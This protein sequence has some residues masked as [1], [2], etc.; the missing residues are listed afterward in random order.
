MESHLYIIYRW[1]LHM[2]EVK[3][4]QLICGVHGVGKTVFAKKLSQR[5]LLEYYSASELIKEMANREISDYKKVQHIS[6]NQELL[7]EALSEIN[8]T[9]YILDGHLCLVNTQ[10]KIERIS[11]SIF[12]AMNIE[13]IFLVVDMPEKIQHRL[14]NRDNQIWNPGFIASFQQ[15]E[16]VYAKYLAKKMNIPLKIIQENEEVAKCSFLERENIILSIKPVFAQ[17]ILSGEKK[18]EYRKRLCKKEVN[19]IYIYATDPVKMII[20]EVGVVNK[21]SMGKEE[22]WQETQKYGGITKKFYDQYFKD[23]DCAYAYRIGEVRQYRFPVA[24]DSI[25]IEYVPQSFTYVGELGLC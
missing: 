18:Y 19:K 9:Q 11:Y 1:L 12:Q 8:D 6:D 10:N 16:F 21:I 3:E 22:L 15:E 17:K 20:G 14:R 4:V 5:L 2:K 7:L 13:N 25:G 23:Q 24:L